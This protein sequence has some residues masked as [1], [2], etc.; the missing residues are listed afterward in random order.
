MKR[1]VA[2]A[3]LVCAAAPAVAQVSN[4]AYKDYFLVGQFGEVC[5]MCE[6]TVLCEA[7]A[8]QLPSAGG[9]SR[10]R[11][12]SLSIICRRALS[13]RRLSTIWEW[14]VSPISLTE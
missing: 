10:S 14:F 5:T 2:I 11:A 12:T 13:G 1:L 7:S 8:E 3:L 6:V 9:L 4:D